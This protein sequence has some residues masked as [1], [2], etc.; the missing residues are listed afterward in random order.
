MIAA[1]MEALKGSRSHLVRTLSFYLSDERINRLPACTVTHHKEAQ[2]AASKC[3]LEII[4]A[5]LD[6]AVGTDGVHGKNGLVREIEL[7]KELGATEEK[8]LESIGRYGAEVC[9]VSDITGTIEPGK[10]ADIVGVS[11]SPLERISALRDIRTVVA[12]GNLLTKEAY[13]A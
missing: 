12:R 2:R 8:I 6:F 5:G 1:D 4:S 7:L 9:D 13:L 11:E 10:Y 3:M